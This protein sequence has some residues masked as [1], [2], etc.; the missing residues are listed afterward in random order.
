VFTQSIK[1]NVDLRETLLSQAKSMLTTLIRS[2]HF[3]NIGKA[4]MVQDSKDSLGDH[5]YD[6]D[7]VGLLQ[8]EPT[9]PP[10][11]NPAN[12]QRQDISAGFQSIVKDIEPQFLVR[13]QEYGNQFG[14]EIQSLR[15]E[16]VQFGDKGMQEKISSLSLKYAELSAQEATLAIERKVDLA[17]A[18]REKQQLMIRAQGEADRKLLS[19][20]NESTIMKSKQ[21]LEN[22]LMLEKAKAKAS[23]AF[24][25]AEAEAK[26]KKIK[27]DAEAEYIRKIG[28][29]EYEVN[30]RSASLPYANIRI[31]TDAQKEA[32]AGVQKI[33][34]TSDQNLLLKPYMNIMEL[35]GQK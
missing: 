10:M 34:Y 20:E 19:F 3:S 31:I 4:K 33:V 35:E 11:I 8:V 30:Q 28:Q 23:A 12:G 15:I 9:A 7:S 16:S 21:Q 29:A 22:D 6:K 13:M 17:Q 24:L 27:A 14:F 26:G 18:E 5:F 2:E 32:L 25:E 1:D